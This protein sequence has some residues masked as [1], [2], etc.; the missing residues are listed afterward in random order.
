MIPFDATEPQSSQ[1]DIFWQCLVIEDI[2]VTVDTYRE[3][4][5][6]IRKLNTMISSGRI[7][8]FYKTVAMR[9]C[10]GMFALTLERGSEVPNYVANVSDY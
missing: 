5:M 1:Y 4:T 7:N 10:L 6:Q 9:L 8:D 2:D 3:K